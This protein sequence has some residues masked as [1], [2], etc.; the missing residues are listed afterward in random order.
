VEA[1]AFIDRSP[2]CRQGTIFSDSV[3]WLLLSR[4][5]S[6]GPITTSGGG[7]GATAARL[8]QSDH[9]ALRRGQTT[10]TG[11]ISAKWLGSI[12]SGPCLPGRGH[13]G[14]VCRGRSLHHLSSFVW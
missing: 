7:R 14:R 4:Q 3:A 10:S 13:V 2:V 8:A 5:P 6:S 12:Q 1:M 9:Y 11:L